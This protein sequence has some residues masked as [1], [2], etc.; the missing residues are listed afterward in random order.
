MAIAL[1]DWQ[2]ECVRKREPFTLYIKIEP[3]LG[4]NALLIIF[5]TEKHGN[6]RGK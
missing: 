1:Q 3:Q 4:R 6:G 2:I 5:H